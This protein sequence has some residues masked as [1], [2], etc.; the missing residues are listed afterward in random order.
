VA[1]RRFDSTAAHPRCAGEKTPLR[2]TG[3]EIGFQFV[4][5]I[6]SGD[7][8]RQGGV[9]DTR[10]EESGELRP[11]GADLGDHLNLDLVETGGY[12]QAPELPAHSWMDFYELAAEHPLGEADIRGVDGGHLPVDVDTDQL[13][14]GT[15]HADHLLKGGGGL[16]DV[17]EQHDAAGE[18]EGLI[19]KREGANIAQHELGP[20]TAGNR[21]LAGGGDHRLA[22]V[23]SNDTASRDDEFFKIEG[24]GPRTATSVEH[25]QSRFQSESAET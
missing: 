18:V 7:A 9:E 6:E 25:R 13:T 2:V 19:G 4:K 24:I 5:L 16:F 3:L 22:R 1:L 20:T 12:E 17:Q 11:R 8:P 14:T 15:K 10:S 23:D 21:P